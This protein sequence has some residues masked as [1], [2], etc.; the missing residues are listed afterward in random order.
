ML[1]FQNLNMRQLIQ[2]LTEWNGFANY[3][4]VLGS[5]GFWRVTGRSLLFTAANV[6]LIM[7]LGTLVGL[8]LARLGKRMRLTLLDRPG[9]RLGHAGHRRHHRLPVALRPSGTASSTGC[10]TTLGLALHGRLQLVRRP[11]LHLLRDHAADR[12]AV[13][14]VRRDQPVRR[15]R[16]PSPRSCTR[17][18]RS[19]APAPGRSSPRSPSRS[20]G[21]SSD[22][23]TFLEVIWVFKAFAQVFAHQP[24]RP[25][26]AHRDPA[27]STPTSRASATS[28][29]AWA[30]RSRCSPS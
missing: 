29:S 27:A 16:R 22:A 11:A 12:L 21:R 24:G 7:V 1:S 3:T 8:L 6:V 20:S 15:H 5:P 23:T 17:P 26:P 25:R 10:W 2:H 28:T 13:D 9:A 4:E 14:P 19:T 30:R 18:P